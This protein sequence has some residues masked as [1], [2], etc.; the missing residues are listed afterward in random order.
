MYDYTDYLE[1]EYA[2][3]AGPKRIANRPNLITPTKPRK[4]VPARYCECGQKL[5]IVNE[6]VA[7]F[8]CTKK[9]KKK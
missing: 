8:I 3:P 5:S 9:K 6:G 7:C 4:V 1:R 2:M